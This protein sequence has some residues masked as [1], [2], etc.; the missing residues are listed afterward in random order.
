MMKTVWD[1]QNLLKSHGLKIFYS[2]GQTRILKKNR[3]NFFEY[4]FNF[5]ALICRTQTFKD[6]SDR[7]L[8]T[9]ANNNKL[10]K[11]RFIW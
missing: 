7:I 1:N 8:E 9:N 2:Q 5:I 10:I 6:P 11:S 3:N 4:L